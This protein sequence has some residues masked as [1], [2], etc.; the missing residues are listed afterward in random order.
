MSEAA[1][2]TTTVIINVSF[3]ED[4]EVVKAFIKDEQI[5]FISGLG[6]EKLKR[7]EWFFND[8]ETAA[9]LVEVFDDGAAFAE[10]GGKAL[11][12]PVNLRFRELVNIES[13]TILGSISDEFKAR[14][15]SMGAKVQSYMGGFSFQ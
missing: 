11:G 14:L 7:F 6:V 12:T 2:S 8:D 4:V 15:A 13:L 9:T 3:N 5:P 10:L 1:N